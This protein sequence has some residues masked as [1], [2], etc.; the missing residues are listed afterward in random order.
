MRIHSSLFAAAAI[1][2]GALC[3]A[4]P[5]ARAQSMQAPPG[6]VHFGLGAGATIPTGS[7]SDLHNTGW[8]LQG[9]VDWMSATS[10]IGF[11]GDLGYTSL[12]GKDINVGTTTLHADALHLWS[13]T[14][15][16]V[17]T[18]RSST[19]A[20]PFVPYVLGGIGLYHRNGTTVVNSNTGAASVDG[21]ST[22][23]GLNAGVGVMVE[24]SGF[25]T[26]AEARFH[27]VFSGA[28][29]GAGNKTSAHYFPLTVGIRFGGM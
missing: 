10:P 21:S 16:A 7:V 6:T 11:R 5:A 25:S 9:L 20:S 23:F 24:L 1:A 29:D 15:D 28:V 3:A 13:A 8:H 19:N 12:G 27:N 2:A 4:V 17:W 14:G 26:F 18:F 22:N